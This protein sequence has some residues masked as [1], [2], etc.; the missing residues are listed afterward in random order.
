MEELKDPIHYN[1]LVLSGGSI[2]GCC[3]LGALQYFYDKG[4]LSNITKYVGTSIGAIICYL[5]AIGYTPL[6]LIVYTCTKMSFQF[7]FNI[8]AMTQGSG[9]TSYYKIQEHLEHLTM[10]KLGTFYTL[11]DLQL[12][13]GKSLICTTYNETLSMVEYLSPESYPELPCLTALRMSCNLPLIFDRFE[14]KNNFYLDGG[15]ADNFPIDVVDIQGNKILGLYIEN[16]SE[17]KQS[18]WNILDYIYK[19]M[20]IPIHQNTHHKV[21]NIS[22]RCTIL[23]LTSPQL[24]FFSI[25]Q[26][27]TIKLEM[28]SSGYEEAKKFLNK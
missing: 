12:R 26:S 8:V 11:K 5:L 3:L 18:E 4:Q 7:I 25:N 19:L 13:L 17:Q 27:S 16:K 1:T 28:F 21:K 6:E 2:K 24:G 23:G 10:K 20:F 22:D 9:A 15:L 14:Y